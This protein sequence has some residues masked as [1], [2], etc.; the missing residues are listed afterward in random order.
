MRNVLLQGSRSR[1]LAGRAR[2]YRFVR[3][4]VS[5][6]LPG[7]TVDDALAVARVLQAAGIG[8][9]LTRLGEDVTSEAE[10]K[11]IRE[12][13]AIARAGAPPHAVEVHMLYG[14]KEEELR[15]L[16]REG[17]RVRVLISY[18]EAWFA[19][20][21]RRLAERPANLFFVVQHLVVR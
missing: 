17:Y 6:F 3:R 7:E 8:A 14:I 21:I 18:G 16:A 11:L 19:W 2:H 1:W 10:V 20:Y 9:L 12:T 15:R 13:I 5:R 4:A